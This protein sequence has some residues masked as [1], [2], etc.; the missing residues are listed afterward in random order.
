MGSVV[1]VLTVNETVAVS[2]GASVPIVHVTVPAA[3]PQ[4]VPPEQLT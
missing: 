3:A 4:E 1:L 2:P